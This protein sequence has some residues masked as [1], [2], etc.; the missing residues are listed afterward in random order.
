MSTICTNRRA[1]HEYEILDSIECGIV[2]D[3]AE[4]KSIK[5]G[6]ISLDAGW[7]NV[8]NNELWLM[9]VHIDK[10]THNYGE[11]YSPTRKRKL[12]LR[13]SEIKKFAE[14]AKQKGLTLI[15]LTL[16]LAH[17]LIKCKL[18]LCK[19]KKLYDKRAAEREKESR[20]EISD[21]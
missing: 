8:E 19:G 20:R 5:T 6:K 2:L 14:R 21:R 4:V 10:K 17:G 11:I 1:Y 15:P 13:R 12:L 7:A 16:Y 3:G 18:G 9:N